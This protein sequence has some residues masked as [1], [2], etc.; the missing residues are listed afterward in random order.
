MGLKIV[1]EAG[2]THKGEVELAK[3]CAK[4]AKEA[5][6]DSIKFIFSNPDILIATRHRKT[7]K[8]GSKN[9]Y[10]TIKS[11]Q[12]K[13]AEIKDL[14]AYCNEIG[15]DWFATIGTPDYVPLAVELGI[16]KIKI[17]AW[18]CRNYYLFDA[19]LET[20]LPIWMDVACVIAGEVD[21]IFEYLKRKNPEVS[22]TLMYESHGKLNFDSIPYLRN[23]YGV[24]VGYSSNSG[25]GF[26]ID[27]LALDYGATIVE[28]RIKPNDDK[29]HHRDVALN[30]KDFE[31]FVELIH[32]ESSCRG[33]VGIDPVSYGLY[34]SFEDVAAKQM[35][36]TSLCLSQDVKKGQTFG[37]S[38]FCA[39]RPG[40][41]LSPY[42][43]YMFDGMTAAKD[44]KKDDILTYDVCEEYL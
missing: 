40:H 3:L 44:M 32:K 16:K 15:I 24:E 39:K 11:Y 12:L 29:G 23:R 14:V 6:A 26:A 27:Y 34:P 5:G 43:D 25:Q 30:P 13:D 10:K 22:I 4:G 18:D 35:Y 8:Y 21:N 31:W 7:L 33:T 38:M 19:I 41:G 9:L 20:K 1:A 36:L 17:G 28:K 2:S 37:K 42:Y